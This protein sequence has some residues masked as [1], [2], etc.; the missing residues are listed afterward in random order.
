VVKFPSALL[1][2]LILIRIGSIPVNSHRLNRLG[3]SQL[4]RHRAANP[5]R[6]ALRRQRDL[7]ADLAQ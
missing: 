5:A 3:G 2:C 1:R 4:A 7:I 6:S